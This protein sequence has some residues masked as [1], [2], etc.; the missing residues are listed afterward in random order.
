M[1]YDTNNSLE[2]TGMRY[3]ETSGGYSIFIPKDWNAIDFGLKYKTIHGPTENDFSINLIFEDK[4][5]KGKI[6]EVIDT[7]IEIWKKLFLEFELIQQNEF[8][9]LKNLKCE[10][11]IT[12]SLQNKLHV[13][14]L[15]YFLY[16]NNKK[17]MIITCTNLIENKNIDDEIIDKIIN[18]FEW[19]TDNKKYDFVFDTNFRNNEKNLE[20]LKQNL[21]NVAPFFGAGI[22]KNYDYPLW[23]G[24]VNEIINV[25]EN[26]GNS[27]EIKKSIL[28]ARK[29]LKDKKYMDA[30]DALMNGVGSLDK[31]LEYIM[32]NISDREKHNTSKKCI[33]NFGENLVLFP[34]KTYLTVNYDKVI[35]NELIANHI[36]NDNIEI[37]TPLDFRGERL[38]RLAEGKFYVY[39]LHGVYTQPETLIFSRGNYDDFYG[40]KSE[41][42]IRY[43]SFGEKMYELYT[44]YC[45]LFIGYSFNFYQD[46]LYDILQK[47][48]KDA[49][50]R[51]CHYAFLNTNSVENLEE[52]ERELIGLKIKVI[53]YSAELDSDE[54]H[55]RAINILFDSIFKK[56]SISCESE[57][58]LKNTEETTIK[59][60]IELQ[61]LNI[62]LNY[63]SG[64]KYKFSLIVDEMGKYYVTDNGETYKYLDNIFELKE[65]DV[66]KNLTAIAR[67]FEKDNL[68]VV[69]YGQNE[70][71]NYIRVELKNK[72]NDTGFNNELEVAKYTLVSCISFMDNMRI[73][74]I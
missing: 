31:F 55:Q 49:P 34:S 23:D 27:Q 18:T 21:E 30:I 58:S 17:L 48:S 10:K 3:T 28:N 35:E 1:M 32:E 6:N 12:K 7:N 5:F 66:V 70:S 26:D 36:S 4:N 56:K 74:Y 33:G 29:K 52:K 60:F 72:E 57:N 63:F 14:Q 11:L 46:R 9:T 61:I 73:F 51:C 25:I 20:S 54:Q 44:T 67:I 15:C 37:L 43:R 45:F 50:V 71:E 8:V 47:I 24:L 40:A 62:P 59:P 16:G 65:Y 64:E 2:E 41:K 42:N 39:H 53:W 68:S 19:E 22:S 13:R 38:H 69:K